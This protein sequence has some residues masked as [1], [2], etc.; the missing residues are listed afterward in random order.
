MKIPAQKY[1]DPAMKASLHI[2]STGRMT[3]MT[4]VKAHPVLHLQPVI[5]NKAIQ[6]LIAQ[7][8]PTI[9]QPGDKYEQEADRIAEQVVG[10]PKIRQHRAFDGGCLTCKSQKDQLIQRNGSIR[11][12]HQPENQSMTQAA[13]AIVSEVLSSQGQQLDLET[14]DFMESRLD[15]D[16]DRIRIHTGN[17]AAESARAVNA[18]AYTVGQNIVFGL[19][20]YA[21]Q[22]NVGKQ[23]LA[24]ELVHSIQQIGLGDKP[25]RQY[26]QRLQR[27]L[28]GW[29]GNVPSA[30]D[31]SYLRINPI[32]TLWVN[33]RPEQTKT[34]P[35]NSQEERITVPLNSMVAL[36]IAAR[37][38]ALKDNMF[39]NQNSRWFV[40][41]SWRVHVDNRGNVT[42]EVP[43]HS[44]EDQNLET[45]W[46]L[47]SDYRDSESAPSIGLNL[48][49]LDTTTSSSGHQVYGEAL[50]GVAEGVT[51]TA[52]GGY[53][54]NWG[55]STGPTRTR[56]YG[57]RVGINV[58][59][60]HVPEPQA[61]IS[62][63]PI[64]IHRR[65]PFYFDFDR[66]T[67]YG[68]DDI[69][70]T[71]YL[72]SLGGENGGRGITGLLRASASRTG[73]TEYNRDLARR[74][75][76]FVMSRI[77]EVLPRATFDSQILGED[78]LA[79]EGIPEIDRDRIHQVVLIECGITE[80]EEIY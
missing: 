21:P 13:P 38:Y 4:D 3:S 9:S 43:T 31:S 62:S 33:G 32:V 42:L 19:G 57:F 26:L 56:G 46:S 68:D 64:T 52:T 45:P 2:T 20:Q 22:T 67:L 70:L 75:A 50:L 17:K 61:Q 69:R 54:F 49:L 63:G 37:I 55:N 16:L 29:G 60:P 74:R 7:A 8:K 34:F 71:S 6:R 18:I 78:L 14:R 11:S 27:P 1:E 35:G 41:Y 36:K 28:S 15:C 44:F 48:T 76:E 53:A 10:M 12:I 59:E 39:F 72:Y 66:D 47:N 51:A 23:V 5:G 79:A 80:S 40:W 73:G 58:P 65:E 77:R 24:H 30:M 25:E